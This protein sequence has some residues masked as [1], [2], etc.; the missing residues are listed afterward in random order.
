MSIFIFWKLPDKRQYAIDKV[1]DMLERSDLNKKDEELL[2][3]C[4]EH[5]HF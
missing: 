1:Q 3:G 4:I 5:T 2:I